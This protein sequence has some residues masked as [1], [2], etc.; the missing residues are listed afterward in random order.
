MGGSC[1]SLLFVLSVDVGDV[2]SLDVFDVDSAVVDSML[3]LVGSVALEA[4]TLSVSP[5]LL[6]DCA[7]YC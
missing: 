3:S 7:D 5:V 2:L 4:P 1:S 6:S